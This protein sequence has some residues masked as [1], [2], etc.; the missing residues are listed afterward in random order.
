MTLHQLNVLHPTKSSQIRLGHIYNFK[1][2][3][4]LAS[5]KCYIQTRSGPHLFYNIWGIFAMSN[6]GQ[7]RLIL[8][9]Y[10]CQKWP[11]LLL[12]IWAI[13]FILYVGHFRLI[14][15]LA[16]VYCAASLPKLAQIC[17]KGVIG[18]DMH[19][20]KQFELKCVLAVCVHNHPI[21]IKIHPVFF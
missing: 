8:A 13:F 2:P 18:C 14:A 17:F 7:V 19:F 5:V 15:T 20:Y 6:V 12:I 9:P 21:M 16:S 10:I 11:K 1:L 3:F 4:Q